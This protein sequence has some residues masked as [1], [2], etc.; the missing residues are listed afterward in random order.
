MINQKKYKII[1]TVFFEDEID[2]LLFRFTE[3]NDSVDLFIVLEGNQKESVFLKNIEMFK[4]WETKIIHILSDPSTE[5]EFLNIIKTHK[6][7]NIDIS[8]LPSNEKLRV[9]QISDLISKILT[10]NLNFDDVVLISEIDEL[11]EIPSMN[12]LQEYLSFEPVFFSQK[13]FLWSKD[14]VNEQNHLGT[15][16][17]LFS[18]FIL[19]SHLVFLY[20]FFKNYNTI[21]DPRTINFGYRFSYFNSIQES[22]EKISRK[23]NQDDLESIENLINNSRNNLLYYDLPSQSNPKPLKKYLGRLPL[24]IDMLNT[25]PIGREIPKKHLVIIGIDSFHD[26][27]TKDFESVSIITHTNDISAE[28]HKQVHD[29]IKIHYIQIP[30]QKYY[31]VFVNDN[32]LENFQKMYFLNEIKKIIILQH[33]LEI[34]IFEFYFAGKTISY[35]WS[36]IK[37]NFIYDLLHN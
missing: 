6:L 16:C 13:N 26:I 31:D 32:T 10:L 9:N 3:L 11:P 35:P 37:D 19:S 21:Y 33:P 1:D 4:K 5:D 2:Y 7:N 17:Y 14:F 30:N 23:Y 12:I 36:I 34:D 22:I 18:H 24:N 28:E 29:N 8:N 25:Q 27:D 15:S 20:S